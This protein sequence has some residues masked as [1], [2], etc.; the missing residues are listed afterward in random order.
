M[1][2]PRSD[3]KL[4]A[5]PPEQQEQLAEWLTIENVSYAEARKRVRQRFGVS[6]SAAALQGFY[7]R[8]A[9]PWKYLRA[10]G[11]ADQFAALMEGHFDEASI[12]RAKQLAFEAM[13]APRPDLKAAKALLK[14]VGDS[15]KVEIARQKLTLDSRKVAVLEAKAKLADQAKDIAG[16][17]NLSDEE[18][19][20]RVRSLFG[21]G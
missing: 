10:K 4:D 19:A 1:K 20:Q 9:A 14:I 17:A 3:S 18:K 8:F 15:A 6:T 21:M 7:S 11:E 2:K 16:D 13:T 12:K 5:L